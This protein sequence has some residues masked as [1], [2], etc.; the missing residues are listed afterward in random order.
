I[1]DLLSRHVALVL[2]SLTEGSPKV[3]LEAMSQGV[4]V[5]A[6]RAGGIPDVI[7]HERDGLLVEP[8]DASELAQAIARLRSDRDLRLRLRQHALATAG[9]ISLD[10]QVAAMMRTI[11]HLFCTSAR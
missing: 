5:I 1:N 6:S 3:V 8:G 4:C 11:Q 7:R 10:S 9:R 2:P